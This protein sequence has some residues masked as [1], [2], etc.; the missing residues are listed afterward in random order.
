MLSVSHRDIRVK[1]C[2]NGH[3]VATLLS[4]RGVAT[5]SRKYSLTAARPATVVAAVPST[6][7]YPV[8]YKI[9]IYIYN[10]R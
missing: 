8:N 5:V 3:S 4:P 10:L 7:H 2:A 1:N 6:V 9:Y